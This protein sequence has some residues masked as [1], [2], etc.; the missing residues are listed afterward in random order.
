VKK[1]ERCTWEFGFTRPTRLS[2]TISSI[3]L[4]AAY[5]YFCPNMPMRLQSSGFQSFVSLYTA[6][7]GSRPCRRALSTSAPL[8]AVRR[9]APRTYTSGPKVRAN[10]DRVG[11]LL[12]FL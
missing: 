9:A 3:L 12:T 7:G 11:P 1:S 6:A 5:C 2:L 10:Y 4:Y 8:A